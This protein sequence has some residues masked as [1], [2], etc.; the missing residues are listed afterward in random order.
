MDVGP[1]TFPGSVAVAMVTAVGVPEDAGAGS[2]FRMNMMRT[3]TC[4]QVLVLWTEAEEAELQRVR[5]TS[6]RI[7]SL[8]DLHQGVKLSSVQGPNLTQS[9]SR[10]AEQVKYNM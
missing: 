5:W 10:R 2:A 6:E 8:Q 4:W 9:D 3:Q 7:P 1:N